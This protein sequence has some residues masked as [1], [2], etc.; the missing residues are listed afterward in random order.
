MFG[1][2]Y[3]RTTFNLTG[4]IPARLFYHG[5]VNTSKDIWGTDTRTGPDASGEY[6]YGTPEKTAFAPGKSSK[7]L[8][9]NYP[10]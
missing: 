1:Q 8:S 6:T 2:D 4:A 9:L 5:S 7:F 10:I 3:N